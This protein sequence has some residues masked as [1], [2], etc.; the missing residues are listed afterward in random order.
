M[1][2]ADVGRCKFYWKGGGFLDKRYKEL[3]S[4]DQHKGGVGIQTQKRCYR[5][6]C[7]T[8]NTGISEGI[9]LVGE[10]HLYVKLYI[11]LYINDFIYKCCACV[12]FP[13]FKS[14]N[15]FLNIALS[16]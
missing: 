2:K 6:F 5:L 3:Q 14:L 15:L 1:Q 10:H 4:E 8:V 7:E 13:Q 16:K 11:W 9:P 12:F